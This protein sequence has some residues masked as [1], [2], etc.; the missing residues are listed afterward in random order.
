MCGLAG[1]GTVFPGLVKAGQ[2]MSWANEMAGMG[3]DEHLGYGWKGWWFWVTNMPFW[4]LLPEG[5][6]PPYIY[7]LF[8][9]K[10]KKVGRR[11]DRG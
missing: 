3:V 5:T 9:G 2:W 8:D 10:R 7:G 4:N 6:N 1:R 11:A